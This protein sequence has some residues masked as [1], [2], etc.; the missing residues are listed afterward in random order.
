MPQL[1]LE[2]LSEEI[3]ARMQAKAQAD[4]EKALMDRLTAAVVQAVQLPSLDDLQL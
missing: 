2:I 4:L 1:L 3:P